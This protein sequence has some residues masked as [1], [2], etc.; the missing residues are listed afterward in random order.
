MGDIK[1][2]RKKYSRPKHPWQKERIEEEKELKK[3]YGL[4]RN[5]EIW[6]ARSKLKKYATQAKKLVALR[7]EQAD[8][9]KK[10]L[11]DKLVKQ[12]L[13]DE[14]SKDLSQVLSL[15]V[16]DILERRRKNPGNAVPFNF[17]AHYISKAIKSYMEDANI[18]HGN[19]QILRR[20]FGS[21][22]VQRGVSI[23]K[24]SKLLGHG[25]IKVTEQ[26]YTSLLKENLIDFTKISN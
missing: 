13:L 10:Q 17:T 16:R 4:M 24:V 21:K 8:K 6:K 7:G 22:L 11:L 14:S 26:F 25:S 19:V 12:G 9:E 23:Y 15:T 3:E 2:H 18:E 5:I 1:K 20:T